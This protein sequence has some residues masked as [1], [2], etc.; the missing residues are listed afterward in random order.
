MT[1]TQKNPE[2]ENIYFLTE[3]LY[4]TDSGTFSFF[5]IRRCQTELWFVLGLCAVILMVCVTKVAKNALEKALAENED[6]EDITDSPELPIV[7]E[8]SVNLNEPL[9]IKVDEH[10]FNIWQLD[11]IN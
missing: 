6:L 1:I 7:A 4:W 11:E 3:P 10:W 2:P 9:I 5:L 8:S